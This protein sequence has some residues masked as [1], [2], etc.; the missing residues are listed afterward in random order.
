MG[1]RTRK[2]TTSRSH[3]PL[4]REHGSSKWTSEPSRREEAGVERASALGTSR[5]SSLQRG[6]SFGKCSFAPVPTLVGP[7]KDGAG[8]AGSVRP[9]AKAAL[10]GPSERP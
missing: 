7:P 6:S 10:R 9:P 5:E 8:A 4:E 2:T 3:A 1:V